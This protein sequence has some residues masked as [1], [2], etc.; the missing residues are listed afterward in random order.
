MRVLVCH[1]RYRQAG[2]EDAVF[3]SE[4]NLLRDAG[5]DVSTLDLC[6]A[7]L[8]AIPLR[9]RARIA[10]RYSDHEWG[11]RLIR[12]AVSRHRPEVVHFHN[13]YPQLGPGAIVEADRLGCATVHT[14]HNYRLSCLAGTHMRRSKNCELCMPGRLAAGVVYGCYRGS[15]LQSLV[16]RGAASRQWENAVSRSQ[17]SLLVALTPLMK[18][19][20]VRF[21]AKPGRIVVKANSVAEGIPSHR[22]DRRGMFCGGRLSPEKGIL[23]LIRAWPEDA[24]RLTIAGFGPL[25]NEVRAA[26]ERRNLNFVGRLRPEEMRSAM[27]QAA[28]VIMP[29]IWPEPHGLVALDAL[30]EGTPIVAFEGWSLGSLAAEIAPRC[31]VPFGDFLGLAQRALEL[32]SSASWT[33]LSERCLWLWRTAFSHAANRDALLGI[34]RS[35]LD[36]KHAEGHP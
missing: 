36:L 4:V 1:N 7:D 25:E 2:G 12:Q 3:D 16:A 8:D 28:I 5:I 17:P 30:A 24:P 29:S 14:L 22:D 32:G 23:S 20:Y 35:A 9:D 34:Y 18:A 26:A 19:R 27:R 21:G 31:A 6:A 33:E 11:R 10:L 15:R 13:V